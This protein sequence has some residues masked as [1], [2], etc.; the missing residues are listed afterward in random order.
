MKSQVN[1]H[2]EN[3]SFSYVPCELETMANAH[4]AS[5]MPSIQN[6]GNN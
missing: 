5:M 6:W 2:S 1:Q 3:M 4:E